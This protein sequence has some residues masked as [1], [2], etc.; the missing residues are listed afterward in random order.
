MTTHGEHSIRC[1]WPLCAALGCTVASLPPRL[2]AG[3]EAEHASASGQCQPLDSSS[4]RFALV[5][6][7]S[8]GPRSFGRASSGYAVLVDGEPRVL[9]DVG[10]GTFLRLG[11]LEL[12]LDA[13]DTV[14]LTHLHVDHAGDLPGFVKAREHAN[15]DR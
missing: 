9:I 11:E 2:A 8:G 15:T 7:G 4:S 10:P 3:V 12:D 5:V 14:L 13:L 1:M 6:L